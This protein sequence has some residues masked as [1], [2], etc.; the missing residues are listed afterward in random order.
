MSVILLGSSE[1][2]SVSNEAPVP[3]KRD[4]E[5]KKY[6]PC[7]SQKNTGPSQVAVVHTFEPTLWEAEASDL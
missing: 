3:K 2:I 1:T 7:I 6:L 4:R 5:K